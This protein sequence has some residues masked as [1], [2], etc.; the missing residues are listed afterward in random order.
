MSGA[1]LTLMHLSALAWP[2][3]QTSTGL[4]QDSCV[5]VGSTS[6]SRSMPYLSERYRLSSRPFA[7]TMP[8]LAT[9]LLSIITIQ[10]PS[11]QTMPSTSRIPIMSY[12]MNSSCMIGAW[13]LFTSEI[14]CAMMKSIYLLIKASQLSNASCHSSIARTTKTLSL[15]FSPPM[16]HAVATASARTSP[17]RNS[18]NRRKYA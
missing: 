5:V 18:P 16:C 3:T 2:T 10:T 8:S 15:L 11:A 9:R 1:L 7:A 17:A 14:L 6:S 13:S 4:W 12:V